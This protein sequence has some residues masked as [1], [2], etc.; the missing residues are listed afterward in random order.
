[1]S[2][3]VFGGGGGIQTF[4]WAG[5]PSSH[6]V[7]KP[8]YVSDAGVRGSHWHYD[9]A[10]WKPVGGEALLAS[11]DATTANVANSETIGLQYQM[12]TG[13]WQTG[14]ILRACA[15]FIKSGATDVGT[16]RCRIGTAGTTA[17]TQIFGIN[18]LAAANRQFSAQIDI[19]LESATS[20]QLM[21]NTVNLGYSLN[22]GA[23]AAPVTISSAAAN[24]LFF[25]LN[26][27][28][29]GTTDTVNIMQAQLFLVGKAN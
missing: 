12:P 23:V 18:A 4:T 27:L 17:D 19:R 24:A 11:L 20:A 5:K 16:V 29:G 28:S 21:P 9:G 2:I 14:Y 3:E 13:M 26:M 25:S 10:L 6:P 7:G 8:A 15:S 22:N 1:M